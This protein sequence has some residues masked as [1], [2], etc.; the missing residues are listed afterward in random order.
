VI[1]ALAVIGARRFPMWLAVAATIIVTHSFIG[2]KEY[3]FI[4]PAIAC[5]IVLAGI[6]TGDLIERVTHNAKNGQTGRVV[7]RAAMVVWASTSILLAGAP[8]F[9]PLWTRHRTALQ[10]FAALHAEP[11]LCGV[12]II[13]MPWYNAPGYFGLA[14]HVLMYQ[15]GKPSD[16]GASVLPVPFAYDD[17]YNFALVADGWTAPDGFAKRKCFSTRLQLTLCIYARAGTCAP[18]PDNALNRW[19]IA[20][21][22]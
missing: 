16:D 15:E 11:T 18:D 5:L 14:R 9:A 22:R 8:G 7:L 20:H 10:A 17:S 6:G 2:H 13:G 1:G 12:G 21:D 4:F 3:R 19:L